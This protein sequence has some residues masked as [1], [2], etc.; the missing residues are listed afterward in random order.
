MIFI[1]YFCIF[2]LFFF[3]IIIFEFLKEKQRQISCMPKK[4]VAII[5]VERSRSSRIKKCGIRESK[6]ANGN[7]RD[8]NTQIAQ[9][10]Y[11]DPIGKFV[12]NQKLHL[13]KRGEISLHSTVSEC[14]STQYIDESN[15]AVASQ[16]SNER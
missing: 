6:C 1:V 16:F 7:L 11:I 8:W 13:K 15:I 4:M 5:H 12:W 3:S 10:Y 9:K 14:A 2:F